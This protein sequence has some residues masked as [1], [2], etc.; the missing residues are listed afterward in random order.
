MGRVVT[1]Q[2]GKR[3]G[4]LSESPAHAFPPHYSSCLSAKSDD[5]DSPD[6]H[7]R[8]GFRAAAPPGEAIP[9]RVRAPRT[10][11]VIRRRRA[12]PLPAAR[13][14]VASS[15]DLVKGIVS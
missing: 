10:T 11:A 14:R 3:L 5:A 12:H 7:P 13:K 9:L 1:P 2:V 4:N 8:S 15:A 6:R